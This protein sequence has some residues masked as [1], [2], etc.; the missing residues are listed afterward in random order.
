MDT[1][2][3]RKKWSMPSAFTILFFLIIFVAIL[4]WLIPSGQYNTDKAGNIIAGTYKSLPAHPQGLWDIFKAPIEGMV[5][6]STTEGSISVSL[7]ILVIG[8]FLGVVNKTRALDDG[9]ST[10]VKKFAGKEMIM[11]PV[12]MILFA[13][14]GSTYGMGEETIAFYP[15]LIPVMISVGFDSITAISIALIGSQVGCLASTVNPFATGVASQTLNISPGDGLLSRV[16]LLVLVTAISIGYVMY[17]A[18][19]V[20]NDPKKSYV[21]DRREQDM[22]EFS[23]SDSE[24]DVNLSKNQKWVL[25][26]FLLS[27][28][29]MIA[30]LIPW[31]SLN[32]G[33]TVFETTTKNISKVPFLGNFIGHDVAPL[34]TWYFT[35]IT[36]L[37][38]IMSVVIM[39]VY[40]M[41]ESTFIDAFIGGMND[42]LS[43]A[44][45]VAVARGIQVVMNNGF[46]TATVL[47][48]GEQGLSHLSSG[49]FITLTYIFYIPMS[50]LIPSTSGLAAATMGIMGPLG[51]FSNVSPSLVVTAYQAASGWVNVITPTSGVV[52]GALAIGH[53]DIVKWWKYIW[54]LMIILF[55]VSILFLVICTYI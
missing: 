29:I 55:V 13:I 46:I 36:T 14:G 10:T 31:T 54:K 6:T 45:I 20:K 21:Y 18:K 52:M 38:L 23:I 41:K 40:H 43:V 9:I 47:H 33:W 53:V 30:G 11:I 5:G 48:A 12:L 22:K 28:V 35:E 49:I 1:L 16:V 51:K 2:K 17:Y 4:T 32:P 25:V 3:Q 37:F 42:F 27:F 39:F 24:I 44:I 19:K 15:I 8:G 26:L 50:F 7:F 34:G